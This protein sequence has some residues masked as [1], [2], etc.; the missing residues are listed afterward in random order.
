MPRS[1][2]PD[3]A[4]VYGAVRFRQGCRKVGSSDHRRRARVDGEEIVIIARNLS[5][6][7]TSAAFLSFAHSTAKGEARATSRKSRAARRSV[8]P[9]RDRR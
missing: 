7:S 5:G 3:R 9:Q 1:R 6:Y 8:L 2:S 4:G